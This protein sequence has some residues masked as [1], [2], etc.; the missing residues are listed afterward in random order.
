[1]RSVTRRWLPPLAAHK[2]TTNKNPFLSVFFSPQI[3]SMAVITMLQA[4]IADEEMFGPEERFAGLELTA[5]IDSN[6]KH[7]DL[8][9]QPASTGKTTLTPRSGG[10]GGGGVEIVA[11]VAV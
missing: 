11:K 9:R 7:A 5:Y 10:G 2:D 8:E 3:F 1:M 4:F 6:G